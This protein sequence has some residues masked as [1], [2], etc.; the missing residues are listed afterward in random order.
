WAQAPAESSVPPPLPGPPPPELVGGPIDPFPVDAELPEGVPPAWFTEVELG[1]VKPSF[2][3]LATTPEGRLDTFLGQTNSADLDWTVL[4]E[5]AAGYRFAGGAAI[6]VSYRFLGGIGDQR[7]RGPTLD[8]GYPEFF[9]GL[10]GEPFF[11][12]GGAAAVRHLHS[13][14]DEHWLD[15]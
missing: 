5:V 8:A 1:V 6:R 12:N 14:L 11:V 7:S 4:P 9:S 3:R 15:L 13:K 10:S 2:T